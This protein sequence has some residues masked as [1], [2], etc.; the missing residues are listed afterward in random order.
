MK[1]FSVKSEDLFNFQL[2]TTAGSVPPQIIQ[3]ELRTTGF[4]NS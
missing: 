4:E 3:I 1:G 2:V